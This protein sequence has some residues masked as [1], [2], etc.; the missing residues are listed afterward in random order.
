MHALM[1]LS[2]I[3]W[4]ELLRFVHQRERFLSALVRPLVWLIVF[5]AGP[6]ILSALDISELYLPLLHIQVIGA[7]LQVLLLSVLNVFF[8]LDQRRLI[9]L[10]CL[11]FL[12]LNLILTAIGFW[13]GAAFYGYGFTIAVFVTLGTALLLLDRKLGR[14]EYET[15]M[16][17]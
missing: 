7:S 12:A 11:E 17:Q 13:L 14:L 4:R 10:L 16:L 1:A 5:A 15:F 2:A 8:Y 9:L 6:A 3:G